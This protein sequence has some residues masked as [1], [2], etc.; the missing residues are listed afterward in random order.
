MS[1]GSVNSHHSLGFDNFFESSYKICPTK[2]LDTP[3]LEKVAQDHSISCV[4]FWCE[5]LK[6][7]CDEI[8]ITLL[9]LLH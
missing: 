1:M 7:F 2:S 8:N 6:Y 9:L 4:N 5:E 3:A